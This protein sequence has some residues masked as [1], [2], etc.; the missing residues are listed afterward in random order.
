MKTQVCQSYTL[1]F[2]IATSLTALVLVLL[3]II[4][5]P[6]INMDLYLQKQLVG[7]TFV[8]LC[9]G[10]IMAALLPGKCT[11]GSQPHFSRPF[12]ELDASG[13]RVPAVKGHHPDCGKFSDHTVQFKGAVYC[14]AC[15]GLAAGSLVA[16]VVTIF[17]FF[18]GVGFSQSSVLT[19]ILGESGILVGFTQTKFKGLFRLLANSLFVVGGSLIMVGM[20]EYAKSLFVDLFLMGAVFLWIFARVAL[21]QEDHRRICLSCGFSCRMERKGS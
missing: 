20:D 5:P 10:G 12:S 15:L 2:L 17:Y 4:F 3:F 16:L 19:I 13:L 9:V 14:A 11:F 7:T 18:L 1:R 8:A 21:S 6:F